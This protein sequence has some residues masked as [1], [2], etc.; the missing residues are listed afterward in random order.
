M[1][2]EE[3]AIGHEYALREPPRPGVEF[4]RV[5]VLEQVRTKW[6]VRWIEPNPGLEDFVKSVNLIVPWKERRA[7]L[8][9]EEAEARLAR[10]CQEQWDGS[11]GPVS[12]AVIQVLDMTGE[13]HLWIDNDGSLGATPDAL[14][15]VADRAGV[16][17]P[18]SETHGYV[19]RGGRIHEPFD[20]GLNLARAFAAAEPTTVLLDIEAHQ[21]RLEIDVRDPANHFMLPLLNRYRA[22]WALVRQWASHDQAVAM[23]EAEIKRLTDILWQAIWKLRRPDEDPERLAMWI[24]RSLR[25]R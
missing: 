9:D 10:K 6:R 3:I 21:Q 7:L 13:A 25:R 17:V 4:Q 12:N 24:E 19:D 2:K 15:R 16:A 11:N 5:K 20:V 18:H 23:R 14:Q 22:E 1:Q 8:R